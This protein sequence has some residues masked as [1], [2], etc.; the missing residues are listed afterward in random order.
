MNRAL[1]PL[2][3]WKALLG[4][5][6]LAALLLLGSEIGH[7]W[8]FLESGRQGHLGMVLGDQEGL[9]LV[10]QD[11][12][13]LRV[14]TVEPG[15]AAA[16][17]GIRPGSMVAFE[18]TIDR[19]RKFALDEQVGLL[20]REA[21]GV[22]RVEVRAHPAP[23]GFGDYFDWL[24]RYTLSLPALLFCLMIGFKQAEDRACRSLS[25]GFL[26]LSLNAFYMFNYS[27]AGAALGL[28]K[29]INLATFVPIWYCCASFTMAYQPY[30][31]TAIRTLLRR[32]F[33]A[34]RLLAAGAAAYALWF[35]LGHEAPGLWLLTFAGMMAGL[36]MSVTSLAEGLRQSG[37]EV[38]Q[39]HLWLLLSF[40]AGS[41]PPILTWIPALD[42]FGYQGVRWTVMVMFAGLLLMYIGLAYAV[43]RHRVFNFS[44][45]VSR[46]LIF[47]VVSLM[48][49]GTFGLIGFFLA[50]HL[51]GE[52]R[53]A[54][55]HEAGQAILA[56]LAYLAFHKV[57]HR[58]E[59]WIE[60][61]LFHRWHE[62]ER[63]LREFV[64]RAAHITTPD[65][66]LAALVAALDRFSHDAGAAVYLARPDGTYA[67]AA[68]TLAHAPPTLALAPSLGTAL[69]NGKGAVQCAP[70]AAFG[71]L[72]LPMS[73]R[74]S[75]NGVVILGSKAGAETY[76]P[77]EC[78]VLA[79]AVHQIGL[80]LD[81]VR[82]EA[83]ESEMQELTREADRQDAELRL[84]AGRRG[85][86]RP[87]GAIP[88]AASA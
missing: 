52:A 7:G 78:A 84:L 45:A 70:A 11:T 79:Y 67:L 69:R 17:A 21:G 8:T 68:G 23:I 58:V 56:L 34:Y 47:S 83:L 82:V 75:L 16:A 71:E 85:S 12:Q 43:L 74:A 59:R 14:K 77:D 72:A 50:P 48:L 18:R 40:A 15:R 28:A 51:H 62:N 63:K 24:A 27:P 81:A 88:A 26:A 25:L 9:T 1:L 80:D 6:V 49:L 60:R 42:Q 76:R 2:P 4:T 22:R 86:V 36:F 57:H 20:V 73:H 46:A 13:W 38:R 5:L 44:F 35:G 33:P 32:V 41:V 64:R 31:P 65:A 87:P 29:L 53:G 66:L 10:G 30:A 39:R 3:A 19:W 37:G 61:V 55:G 54:S